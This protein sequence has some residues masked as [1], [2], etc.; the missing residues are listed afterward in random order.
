MAAS[1]TIL[2]QLSTELAALA[3]AAAPSVV[4]LQTDTRPISGFVLHAGVIISASERLESLGLDEPVIL[5]TSEG[6]A[7]GR[8]AGRD[9]ST[10]VAALKLDAP[11]A[12]VADGDADPVVMGQAV[13]IVGRDRHGPAC[14]LGI[15]SIAGHAWESLRGGMIDQR[16]EL[17]A[18][19]PRSM[20]GSA[21][22]DA[23]G[24]LVG[25]AVF[26]RG[27][28]V[29]V[30]PAATLRRAAGDLVQYGRIRHGYLG[31]GVQPVCVAC[32]AGVER[33]GL[34]VVSLDRV[35]PAAKAGL[36]Q[37][38]VVLAFGNTEMRSAR[39]LHRSLGPE[40]IGTRVPVAL[41]RAGAAQS[42]D[43]EVGEA[44]VEA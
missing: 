34:M 24:R 22:I 25:M 6:R 44:Y 40:T 13:A 17:D 33:L 5:E 23:R 12:L 30:I 2:A 7:E 20:E 16:I 37:G 21:V 1:S 3:G 36:L 41:L 29:L 35:G 4:R 10:D 27:R 42:L 43:V 11:L 14:V 9:R 39:Q 31:V 15:V 26:G 18:R 28:R 8:I 32:S 38:D 19:L